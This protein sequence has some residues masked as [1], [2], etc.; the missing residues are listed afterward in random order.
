MKR[1]TVK[2]I[3]LRIRNRAEPGTQEH[4]EGKEAKAGIYRAVND[5]LADFAATTRDATKF[6]S[7]GARCVCGVS[8]GGFLGSFNWGVAHGEGSCSSCGHPCRAYHHIT[9]PDG[10]E[11]DLGLGPLPY[12]PDL[13]KEVA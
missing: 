10:G 11:V 13:L 8:L 12:H 2:A 3:G 9:V 7:G 5:Y 6:I 1:L 4:R